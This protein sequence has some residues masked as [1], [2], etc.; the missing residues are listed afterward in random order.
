M[1][2]GHAA[3]V[4]LQLPRVVRDPPS[5]RVAVLGRARE[6]VLRCQPVVD[7][8]DGEPALVGQLAAHAV[9]AGDVADAPSAAVEVDDD[10][11]HGILGRRVQTHGDVAA[12]PRHGVVLDPGNLHGSP[13]RPEGLDELTRLLHADVADAAA[14]LPVLLDGVEQELHIGVEGHGGSL[15]C[16]YA[17]RVAAFFLAHG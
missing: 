15:S 13:E 12:G 2:Q 11:E 8:D 4:D 10:G 9:V 16:G 3:A 14:P 7:A 17:L 1:V 5:R 6:L